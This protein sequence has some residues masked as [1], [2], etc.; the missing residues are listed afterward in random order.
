MGVC[1]RRKS[2]RKKRPEE[3]RHKN[4]WLGMTNQNATFTPFVPSPPSPVSAAKI[5]LP[6]LRAPAPTNPPYPLP[7]GPISSTMIKSFHLLPYL[8]PSFPCL[9][10]LNPRSPSRLL[11]AP[12][13]GISVH[14]HWRDSPLSSI[15]NNHLSSPFVFLKVT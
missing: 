12:S 5:P 9:S 4:L 14:S 6:P 3:K 13:L 7:G 8:S 2:Q 11:V 10:S 1:K 15:L